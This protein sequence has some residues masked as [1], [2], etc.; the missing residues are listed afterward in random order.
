[1]TNRILSS[2]Q[3]FINNNSLISYF[4][5]NIIRNEYQVI[6]PT[7]ATQ[8]CLNEKDC[9]F[10]PIQKP[11]C[12][13]LI[14]WCRVFYLWL[15]PYPMFSIPRSFIDS[16][17]IQMQLVYYKVNCQVHFSYTYN[18]KRKHI[19]QITFRLGLHSPFTK[20]WMA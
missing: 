10:L 5:E 9:V 3:C 11:W 20:L 2:Q 15:L 1:M 7:C 8:C 17:N 12:P 18:Y 19:L 14:F 6:R 13:I 16:L 4:N